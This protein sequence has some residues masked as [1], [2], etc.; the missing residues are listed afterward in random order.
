[1]T[2]KRKVISRNENAKRKRSDSDDSDDTNIKKRTE[3]TIT[4]PF[5]NA[6]HSN[7]SISKDVVL[8]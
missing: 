5:G 3:E 8:Y 6:F 4:F 7:D 1:M 2:T